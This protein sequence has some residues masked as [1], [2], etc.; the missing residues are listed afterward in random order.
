[1]KQH[2]D[3]IETIIDKEISAYEDIE[4]CVADKK[5]VIIKGSLDD[6]RDIDTLL[7]EHTAKAANLARARQMGSIELGNANITFKE[8]VQKA[9][10]YDKDQSLRLAEKKSKLQRIIDNINKVN[11][12]NEKLLKQS[13]FI[14]EK[15][16]GMILQTAVPEADSYN[17]TGRKNKLN[18]NYKM[19]SI[20]TEA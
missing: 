17:N 13:L 2:I 1:M 14:V 15:T 7:I 12:I 5:K 18:E 3:N 11:I 4:K 19:S 8:I 9:Y 16:L 20:S 6:L 10:D